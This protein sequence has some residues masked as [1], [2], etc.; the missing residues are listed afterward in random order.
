MK[1]KAKV[2][3][4]HLVHDHKSRGELFFEEIS[5][6][7]VSF[8]QIRS[9]I[10]ISLIPQFKYILETRANVIPPRILVYHRASEGYTSAK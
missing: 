7:I 3:F 9:T 10:C 5:V 4:A 1:K 8:Q 6:Y 2:M